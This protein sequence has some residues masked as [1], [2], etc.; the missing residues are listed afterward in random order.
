[1]LKPTLS[2]EEFQQINEK[3]GIFVFHS[4]RCWTCETH[5]KTLHEE[6]SD[7]ICVD[8][9]SD[10]DYFETQGINSTPTT[11]FYKNDMV[12]YKQTGMMFTKQISE[13]LIEMVNNGY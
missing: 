8:F 12:V 3:N 5:I 11:I 1:M 13:L 10:P 2:K 6:I 4:F 7:F 9:D